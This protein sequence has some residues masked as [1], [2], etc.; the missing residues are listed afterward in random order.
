MNYIIGGSY[1]TLLFALYLKNVLGEKI[2]IVTHKEDM[3]KFCKDQNIDYI[4][5]EKMDINIF[6]A[7]KIFTL[8]KMLNKIIKEIDINEK[9]RY[10]IAGIGK[11]QNYFYLAKELSKNGGIGY[12]KPTGDNLKRYVHSRFKP[13]FIRGDIIRILFKLFM[14]L[15]LIYYDAHGVPCFGVNENFLKKYNI[16]EYAPDV[17]IE[18]LIFDVA[19]KSK[20]NHIECDNLI[21]DP[22]LPTNITK[23]GSITKL[24]NLLF[25]LPIDFAIK[26][27]PRAAQQENKYDNPLYNLFKHCDEIP[28][29]IPVELCCNNIRK[30]MIAVYSISLTTASKFKHLKAISLLELVEWHNESFKRDVKKMLIKKSN[31]KILF[32]KNF[33]ELKEIL[34]SN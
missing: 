12:Y 23:F 31:N 32:P 25:E 20:I 30:N 9:D 24:Y 3:I 27:H 11:G 26:K 5:Y 17:D 19:K 1:T 6:S 14:G 22:G 33:E 13:I 4:Q 15:D 7:Y 28:I 10:F 2:T 21:I 16:V 8:K 18:E 29:H 34:L